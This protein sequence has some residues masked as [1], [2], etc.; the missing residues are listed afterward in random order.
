M[1][2]QLPLGCEGLAACGAAADQAGTLSKPMAQVKAVRDLG[3]REIQ[4]QIQVRYSW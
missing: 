2:W 1:V 3:S 4:L